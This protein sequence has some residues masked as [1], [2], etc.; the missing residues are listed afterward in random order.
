MVLSLPRGA[1]MQG[2]TSTALLLLERRL[3]EAQSWERTRSTLEIQ[4]LTALAYFAHKDLLIAKRTLSEALTLAQVE[5]Y[6]RLFLDEGE[7]LLP[8]LRAVLLDGQE[9]PLL[10]Y[11]RSLLA[12][13]AH[14]EV[15]QITTPH[16]PSALFTEPLSPQERR[17]LRLLAAGRSNPEIAQELIVSV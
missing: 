5:G 8:V 17:V 12:T 11:S 7:S 13:L 2:E 9:E 15:K 10:T 16:T 14:Q 1:R 6:Q 3:A 4:V